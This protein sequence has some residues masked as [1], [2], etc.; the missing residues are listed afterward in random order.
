MYRETEFIVERGIQ[1]EI[2]VETVI[3]VRILST[4]ICSLVLIEPSP[5][6]ISCRRASSFSPILF[7][8]L[9]RLEG[10]VCFFSFFATSP[11]FSF[12]FHVST[13]TQG[14]SNLVLSSPLARSPSTPTWTLLIW[15]F[16]LSLFRFRDSRFRSW[17]YSICI[18]T[19]TNCWYNQYRYD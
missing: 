18:Y 7:N 5:I 4:R 1:S 13:E 17:C 12:S 14:S 3:N 19:Y 8:S 16:A 11:I 2:I 15:S 9:N 6:I 10:T